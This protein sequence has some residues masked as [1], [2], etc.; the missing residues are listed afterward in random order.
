[1]IGMDF[2]DQVRPSILELQRLRTMDG[3][4]TDL[5]EREFQSGL[6]G[7]LDGL[8]WLNRLGWPVGPENEA[9]R[10]EGQLAMQRLLGVAC[11]LH[12]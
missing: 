3:D 12:D 9:V 5:F 7:R 4:E 1:M 10:I 6:V 11:P 8:G 2:V